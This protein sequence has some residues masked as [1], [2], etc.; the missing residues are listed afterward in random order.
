[1]VPFVVLIILDGWGLAPDS[2]GNAISQAN[3][4]NL[5]SY[6]SAYPHTTLTASG[7]EVGLPRGEVGNT[8]TGHLNL[9]AGRVVYQDL[10]RINMSISD[11][12]FF[13]NT[14]LISAIEHAK[15]N[16][17]NLHLM[18]LVGTGGVHSSTEHLFALINLCKQQNFSRVFLHLFTDGR[19]SPP[20]T[21]I[22]YLQKVENVLQTTGIGTIASIMGRF[23]SLDRDFRWERTQTAYRALT[24]GEGLLTAE[25]KIEIEKSYEKGISDEFLEPLIITKNGTP[26]AIISENDAVVFFNFRIDRPRQ[27]T[28]AFVFEDFNTE[29]QQAFDFDPYEIKYKKTH[30]APLVS[31]G[32]FERGEKIKNMYF[33]TMAQY[34]KTT[35]SY[36]QVAFP[37]TVVNLPLGGVISQNGLRQVRIAE[38]EKERF[39]TF[40]FNGQREIPFSGEERKILPS[41]KVSTYDQKPEMSASE[42]TTAFLEILGNTNQ[43]K[44]SLF[45]LNFANADMVGHTGNLKAAITACE[46]IDKNLGKIV[47][48]VKSIGGV[49]IIT[50]DHGNTEEMLNIDGKAETE[51]SA[52]PVP[53]TIVGEMFLGNGNTLTSGIL[54]DV[55]PTILKLLGIPQPSDMTGRALV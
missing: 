7:E 33:V 43:N 47:Q 8:E 13:K 20:N 23:W 55:A 50:A 11:G 42:I 40:Y 49:V 16:N 51:H 32:G 53:F 41:L 25:Y 36:L 31:S 5:K 54:A 15:K 30:L 21:A 12:S 29:N 22:S 46:V 9:G 19:D 3:L 27:L 18:G 48:S 4:P 28:R 44:Y 1:M 52:N 6:L 39:V 2:P 14:T 24:R 34:E 10:L 37:P 17:S 26:R 38:S 35:L 45:V